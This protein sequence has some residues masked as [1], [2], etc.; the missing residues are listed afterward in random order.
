[1]ARAAVV[2][3]VGA[4]PRGH[5]SWRIETSRLTSAGGGQRRAGLPRQGDHGSPEPLHQGQKHQDLL[6]VTARGEDHED[7]P[8]HDTPEVA[9]DG[10]GGV[11]EDGRGSPSR[12]RVAETFWAMM[13]LLPIP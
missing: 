1:M 12:P 9:V 13:P 3:A 8:L 6:G 10:L 7:V 5:A 2:E 11:Q 4:R